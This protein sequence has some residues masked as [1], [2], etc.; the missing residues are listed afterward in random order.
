MANTLAN[1]ISRTVLISSIASVIILANCR[2]LNEYKPSSYTPQEQKTNNSIPIQQP[3]LTNT[4]DYSVANTNQNS[5]QSPAI[6][7]ERTLRAIR[8]AEELNKKQVTQPKR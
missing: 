6:S 8:Y 4:N 7:Q 3:L 2:S 1:I 5:T